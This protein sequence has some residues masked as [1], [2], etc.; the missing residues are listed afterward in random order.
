MLNKGIAI[1]P[2]KCHEVLSFQLEGWIPA[3]SWGCS[4]CQVSRIIS[5]HA[6]YF[7]NY[8]KEGYSWGT[9]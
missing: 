9:P 5:H 4:R 2:H 1:Q 7:D 6:L 3:R 8:D